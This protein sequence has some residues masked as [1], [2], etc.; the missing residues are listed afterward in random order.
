[1][2]RIRRSLS[3]F[4]RLFPFIV[5]FLRDRKRWILFGRGVRRKAGAHEKRAEKLA[6]AVASLGPTFIKLAQLL[7]AR[8]DI[9]PEPYL[10]AISRLQDRVRP[11]PTDAVV[12]VVE[13]ELDRPLSELFQEFDREPT[14]EPG[15]G[16]PLAPAG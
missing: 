15:P 12:A 14:T 2:K 13:D 4:F 11:D 5:A 1:M 9:L 16:P 10:S 7:S 3:V 6:S 8:A